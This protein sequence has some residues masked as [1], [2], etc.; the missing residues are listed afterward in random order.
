MIPLAR[1]LLAIAAPHLNMNT[2]PAWTK[3]LSPAAAACLDVALA[4]MGRP[5]LLLL[6]DEAHRQAW[7]RR[8]MADAIPEQ[9]QITEGTR[10][11]LFNVE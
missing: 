5:D 7:R 6:Q 10:S 4:G 11:K 9:E 1:S 3:T 2:P 8:V